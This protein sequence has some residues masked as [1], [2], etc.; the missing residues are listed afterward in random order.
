MRPSSSTPGSVECNWV[1]PD[2]PFYIWLSPPNSMHKSFWLPGSWDDF[3][4]K[5]SHTSSLS[6]SAHLLDISYAS[7]HLKCCLSKW[8]WTLNFPFATVSAT[9]LWGSQWDKHQVRK[10]R[11]WKYMLSPRRSRMAEAAC[12]VSWEE[13]EL[14]GWKGVSKAKASSAQE[15]PRG[16]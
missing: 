11:A 12:P 13:A 2:S 6:H 10:G 7:S 3:I 5:P 14:T 8:T 4:C 15:Q 16:T 1:L 9:I